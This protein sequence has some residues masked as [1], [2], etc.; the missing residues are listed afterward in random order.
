MSKYDKLNEFMIEEFLKRTPYQL[1]AKEGPSGSLKARFKLA[2]GNINFYSNG[3]ITTDG[4][5]ALKLS[6]LLAHWND[7]IKNPQ[8]TIF[9]V[10]AFQNGEKKDEVQGLL[11]KWGFKVEVMEDRPGNGVSLLNKLEKSVAKADYGIVLLSPDVELKSGKFLPR[12]NVMMELGLLLGYLKG[13]EH[14]ISVIN[15]KTDK[16]VVEIASDILGVAYEEYSP[17][18][19]ATKL[20]NEVYHLYEFDEVIDH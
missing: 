18:T 5:E 2:N 6:Q 17:A 12:P 10:Y 4:K 13:S 1:L 3:S 7:K 16:E 15:Y 9:I 20:M 8:K 19:I 11:E 14:R